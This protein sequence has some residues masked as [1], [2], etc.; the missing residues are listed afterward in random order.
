MTGCDY[1]KIGGKTYCLTS[2]KHSYLYNKNSEKL[3][4]LSFVGEIIATP[5]TISKC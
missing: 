2:S 3:Y 1:F 4:Y 5:S